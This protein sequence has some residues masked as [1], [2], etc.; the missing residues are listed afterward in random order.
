MHRDSAQLIALLRQHDV[1]LLLSGHIHLYDQ[2]VYNNLTFICDGAVCAKWWL[3]PHIETREGFG[4]FDLY[5]DGRF[6]HSYKTFGW[7][8]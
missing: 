3:G 6:D 2:V 5:A 1:R 4:V 7:K 8:A